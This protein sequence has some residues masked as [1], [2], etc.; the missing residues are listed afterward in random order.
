MSVYIDVDEIEVLEA[1]FG[2]PYLISEFGSVDDVGVGSRIMFDEKRFVVGVEKV[3]KDFGLTVQNR[4][5]FLV[6]RGQFESIQKLK[7]FTQKAFTFLTVSKTISPGSI[8]GP[9]IRLG[10]YSRVGTKADIYVDICEKIKPEKV[11]AIQKERIGKLLS[12]SVQRII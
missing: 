11:R 1:D 9:V 3:A 5:G 7:E 2:P 12:D 10:G 8:L 6:I 4:E